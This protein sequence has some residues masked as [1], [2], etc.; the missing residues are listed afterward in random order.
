MAD[1]RARPVGVQNLSTKS[2]HQSRCNSHWRTQA[3]Y[4]PK[5]KTLVNLGKTL[6]LPETITQS[7][8][9]AVSSAPVLRFCFKLLLS[10]TYLS[11]FSFICFFFFFFIGFSTSMSASCADSSLYSFSFFLLESLLTSSCSK[12]F[13]STFFFFFFIFFLLEIWSD[14]D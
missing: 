4:T 12:H 5:I 8:A 11:F 9:V 6:P 10:S 14:K 7:C 2:C 1:C 13:S 3:R